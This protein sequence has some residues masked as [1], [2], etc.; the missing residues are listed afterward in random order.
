MRIILFLLFFAVVLISGCTDKNEL[1]GN[2]YTGPDGAM[3]R[4]FENGKMHYTSP[5]GAGSLGVYT[6]EEDRAYFD[7][8]FYTWDADIINDT[9]VNDDGE[10]Y[11]MTRQNLESGTDT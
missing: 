6:I 9:L 7:C 4:I 2:T 1:E 3:I 11:I 8:V 5:G 10:T